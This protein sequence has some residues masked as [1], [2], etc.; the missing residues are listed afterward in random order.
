MK[1]EAT[2]EVPSA[3]GHEPEAAEGEDSAHRAAHISGI[4]LADLGVEAGSGA[5]RGDPGRNIELLKDVALRVKVELG[6]GKML[7]QDVLR[8]TEGSVVE[9]EKLAGDPLE[10]YVNDRL[11]GKGEVLVLNE[12]F[13]VRITQIFSPE[14]CLRVKG[15]S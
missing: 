12:N 9:L 7:L 13:C 5:P 2:A 11:V 8:L 14:E 6:R 15:I 3:Q 10:I 1:R 4:E